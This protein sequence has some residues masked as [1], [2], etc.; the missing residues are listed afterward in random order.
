MS[1]VQEVA[2]HA[3]VSTATVSRV[4]NDLPNVTPEVRARVRASML[5][6]NFRPN[7]VARSLRTK[8]TQVIGLII[9]DIQN[10]FYVS[11]ARGIEDVASRN[12]YSLFLCNTDE[13]PERERLY[14]ET[15]HDEHVAGIILASTSE[16]GHDLKLFDSIPVVAL[17][18][19]IKDASC[20]AVLT[21]NVGG[22]KQAVQ[23]LLSLGH[24]RI[25]IIRGQQQI[26]T[27]IERQLG[28]EQ[29]LQEFGLAID[30]DL[31]RYADLRR[32]SDGHQQTFDLLKLPDPP[33]AIFSTGTIFT[34]GVLSAI[35]E[36]GLCVPQDVA[37]VAFDEIPWGELLNPPLTT[38]PQ[39][40]YELGKT[41][42]EMLMARLADPERPP[43]VKRFDLNLIVRESSGWNRNASH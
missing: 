15:M 29:A 4:L 7:R 38:V 5:A 24:R 31:I 35:R 19:L 9:S 18:R 21:D 13:D 8:G 39:P 27:S 36:M 26:T 23:H 28:Y 14:L 30:P 32:I 20:D 11:I 37:L 22:A 10:L 3:G 6:L 40:T 17:D 41:A 42:A 33:T 34:I 12:G 2:K 25:G 1:T 43:S 16:T